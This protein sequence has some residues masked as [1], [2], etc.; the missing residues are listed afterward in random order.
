MASL[1]DA[2][3]A[4]YTAIYEVIE[5]SK[6][7]HAPLRA[8]IVRDAALAFRYVSGGQQPGGVVLEKS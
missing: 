3:D 6:N 4:I 5:E 2:K 8:Q 7:Q 1:G